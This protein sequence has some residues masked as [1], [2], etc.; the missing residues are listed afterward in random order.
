VCTRIVEFCYNFLF[1]GIPHTY[2]TTGE[3]WYRAS[4]KRLRLRASRKLIVSSC[5]VPRI[6][7]KLQ[8]FRRNHEIKTVLAT[9]FSKVGTWKVIKQSPHG[10]MI[11]SPENSRNIDDNSLHS[12]FEKG[13]TLFIP[14][15]K[16]TVKVNIMVQDTGMA[17]IKPHQS[18]WS[19]IDLSALD[20]WGTWTGWI[21]R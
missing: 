20:G 14:D 3:G 12:F 9:D 15:T 21:H 16:L 6:P 7:R 19:L 11:A 2:R 17:Y 18:I 10:R 5:V 1:F 4:L 13:T 8:T